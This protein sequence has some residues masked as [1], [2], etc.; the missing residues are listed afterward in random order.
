M[1]L[2]RACGA[3]GAGCSSTPSRRPALAGR[4]RRRSQTGGGGGST[5]ASQACSTAGTAGT[6]GPRATTRATRGT[7]AGKE[8][9]VADSSHRVLFAEHRRATRWAH[10]AAACTTTTSDSGDKNDDRAKNEMRKMTACGTAAGCP[11]GGQ[12]S[13]GR[14]GSQAPEATTSTARSQTT[15]PSRAAKRRS[16]KVHGCTGRQPRSVRSSTLRRKCSTARPSSTRTLSGTGAMRRTQPGGP[17][18]S[19]ARVVAATPMTR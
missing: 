4:P 2:A 10:T 3:G 13:C 8:P 18:S 5:A 16:A 17:I 11:T 7:A 6:R 15:C 19:R 9:Q 12:R 1:A 14:T